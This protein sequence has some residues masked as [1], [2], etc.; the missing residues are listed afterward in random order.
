MCE[1]ERLRR[2]FQKHSTVSQAEFAR[3]YGIG[4]ASL[5]SQYMTGRRPI[6]LA[7]ACKFARGLGVALGDISLEL[8]HLVKQA[9]PLAGLADSV[10]NT[11]AA[12]CE[13]RLVQLPLD[14]KEGG[15]SALSEKSWLQISLS[16]EWLEERRIATAGLLG[17]EVPD[18][19]MAPILCRGDVAV[20]DAAQQEWKDGAVLATSYE[21]SLLIRRAHRDEGRWWLAGDSHDTARYRPKNG[22]DKHCYIVGR[23]VCR[24]GEVL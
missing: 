17:L 8:E 18:D 22:G 14:S 23:V 9:A 1:A 12:V 15:H 10:S 13:V 6:N 5:M 3:R 4:S 16:K 2:L 24:Y 20:V 7:A 19:G 11:G 21:G